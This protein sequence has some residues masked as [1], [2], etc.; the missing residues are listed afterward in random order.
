VTRVDELGD[1]SLLD[2]LGVRHRGAELV[3]LEGEACQ[4]VLADVSVEV[5]GVEPSYE[6]VLEVTPDA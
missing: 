4:T 2:V 5:V 3:D 1:A 6:A